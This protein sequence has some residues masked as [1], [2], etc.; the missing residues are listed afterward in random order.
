[1]EQTTDFQ[2]LGALVQRGYDNFGHGD[3][4]QAARCIG[5]GGGYGRISPSTTTSR[6]RGKVVVVG[7][8]GKV[9]VLVMGGGE[10]WGFIQVLARCLQLKTWKSKIRF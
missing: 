7:R 10:G 4:G 5:D 9:V 6:R 3:S 2:C 8:G 1:M